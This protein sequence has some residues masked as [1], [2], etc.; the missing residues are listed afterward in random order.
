MVMVMVMDRQEKVHDEVYELIFNEGGPSAILD[1]LK[2]RKETSLLLSGM[3]ALSNIANDDISV[4]KLLKKGLVEQ[5]LD[6]MAAN[7]WDEELSECTVKLLASISVGE[8]CTKAIADR[9]GV[10]LLLSAMESHE[11]EPEFLAAAHIAL[12]N[13]VAIEEARKTVLDLKGIPTIVKQL[14]D[15]PKEAELTEKVIETLIRLSA[16][17]LCSEAMSEEG[18]FMFCGL[19]D[20]W[21]DHV[22]LDE[23]GEEDDEEPS[24]LET[25]L[26]LLGHLAFVTSNLRK[27]VQFDGV[28]KIVACIKKHSEDI[29]VMI[30]AVQTLDNIAMANGEYATI[31]IDEGGKDMIMGLVTQHE[32]DE[33]AEELVDACK[34]A[35][36]SLEALQRVKKSQGA[37][38]GHKKM[39]FAGSNSSATE[40]KVGSSAHD[41]QIEADRLKAKLAE[42]KNTLLSG[43]VVQVQQDRGGKK[44]MHIQCSRDFKTFIFKEMKKTKLKPGQGQFYIECV[45]AVR[46][47][48]IIT[49]DAKLADMWVDALET[50]VT[51]SRK[52]RFLLPDR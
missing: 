37:T 25:I 2:N 3:D 45:Q 41:D 30:K 21:S 18:M 44:K 48:D 12:S 7:D 4:A 40:S 5:V 42:H 23:D 49:S 19:I 32:A 9:N 17:D 51:I 34:S 35:L 10:Q 8:E 11:D 46:S 47:I 6:S 27:L 39:G 38:G 22:R 24:M 13:V 33:D 43:K 52:Y 31:V 16:D 14:K 29:D 50:L 28:K 1:I 26:A 36:L 20:Q 15:F